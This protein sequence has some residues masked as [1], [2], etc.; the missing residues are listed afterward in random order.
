LQSSVF[1]IEGPPR[2]ALVAGEF[3]LLRQGSCACL[4]VDMALVY[5]DVP[6]V[7]RVT[8]VIGCLRPW[9]GTEVVALED[10]GG[11]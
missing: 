9:L 8:P 1:R 10:R 3:L 2:G 5:V 6:L 4:V 7:A 11:S